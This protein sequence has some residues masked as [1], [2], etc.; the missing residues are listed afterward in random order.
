M[1]VAR[2]VSGSIEKINH[3]ILHQRENVGSA[4]ISTFIRPL[5]SYNINT[6][7][8]LRQRRAQF[9]KKPM[10]EDALIILEKYN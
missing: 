3:T 1:L 7:N 8:T 4:P 2:I 6:K 10:H 5:F 9:R